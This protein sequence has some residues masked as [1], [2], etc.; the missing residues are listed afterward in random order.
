MRTE[1]CIRNPAEIQNQVW[2]KTCRP[3]GIAMRINDAKKGHLPAGITL[4]EI[5]EKLD[6]FS[7]VSGEFAPRVLIMSAPTNPNSLIPEQLAV[8]GGWCALRTKDVADL[9]DRGIIMNP[10]SGEVEKVTSVNQVAEWITRSV[11]FDQ[12]VES[13]GPIK[14]SE[15]VVMSERRLW[16]MRIISKLETILRKRLTTD[17]KSDVIQA[18]E[19]AETIRALTTQRYIQYVTGD[20][21]IVFRRVVDEDVWDGL[22]KA[23]DEMLRKGDLSVEKLKLWYPEAALTLPYSSL[24]WAMY[25]EPYF[26]M[27]RQEG[28]MS[29]KK[30][31]IVEPSLHASAENQAEIDLAINIYRDKGI[32]GDRKGFNTNTGFIAY[33]ECVDGKGAN[34]R[35]V[36]NTGEV[37]NVSNW[38][39]LFRQGGM[40]DPQRN[41]TLTPPDNQLFIWGANLL[42]V[43]ST[44]QAL[45]QLATMQDEYKAEKARFG[46]QLNKFSTNG[47]RSSIQRK[48]NALK[49]ELLQKV[50]EQNEII[51]NNLKQLFIYLCQGIV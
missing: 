17:E 50:E 5:S 42:P 49:D 43:R 29:A 15:Y 33:L 40:L 21:N 10:E 2:G 31:Y 28:Y 4:A 46:Q 24:V 37:P 47:E 3:E 14:G 41:L 34:V 11:T 7:K 48:A 26:N 38:Q 25:S 8:A 22:K 45:V 18:V 35:R 32:Y 36:L 23:R 51:A 13:I 19:D 9:S 16:S 27:L 6:R 20:D 12:I 30:A 1:I 39:N 44:L